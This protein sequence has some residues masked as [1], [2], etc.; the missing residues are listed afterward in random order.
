[1][2]S[3]TAKTAGTVLGSLVL[4]MILTASNL[5]AGEAIK[6][7]GVITSEPT[8]RDSAAVGDVE[9]HS[10]YLHAYEGT[11][12]STGEVAFMDGARS[13]NATISDLTKGNGIH[14]GYV[15]F[16]EEGGSTVCYYEGKVTTSVDSDGKAV[17]TYKGTFSF[18]GGTGKYEK[19][20]GNGTYNG[21]FIPSG[22]HWTEWSA[23][24]TQKK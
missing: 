21:K 24:Y 13:Y 8:Q 22:A 3:A 20:M 10:L 7:S 1:M 15:E 5:L 2:R 4:V 9:G 19:I 6:V 14:R 23:E 16:T 11:N 18:T 17:T 12:S